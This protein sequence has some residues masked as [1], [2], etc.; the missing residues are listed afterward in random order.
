MSCRLRPRPLPPQ[1]SRA[2]TNLQSLTG[3]LAEV[4]QELQQHKQAG[5]ASPKGAGRK[6][7]GTAVNSSRARTAVM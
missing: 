6:A 7:F 5:G 3:T 2:L 1:A 4:E